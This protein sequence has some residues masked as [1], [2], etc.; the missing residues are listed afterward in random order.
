[1]RRISTRLLKGREWP[2]STRQI[3]ELRLVIDYQSQNGSMREPT[4]DI[5][6]YPGEWLLDLPLLKLSY[7]DW[8]R[9]TIDAVAA[10][11]TV[12]ILPPIGTA[13]LQRSIRWR[14]RTSRR[15]RFR[16]SISPNI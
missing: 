6:D 12:R 4:L 11:R 5:V 2:E 8:S 16:R 1:M 14:R 3:S 15:R 7:E 9:Q 10:D 13:I